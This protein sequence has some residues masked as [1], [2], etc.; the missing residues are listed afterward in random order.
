MQGDKRSGR[1]AHRTATAFV[2]GLN[3]IFAH[4]VNSAPHTE[5][6]TAGVY[7]TG[8]GHRLGSSNTGRIALE[9]RTLL[10]DIPHDS[11]PQGFREASA[12]PAES[13]SI[14]L[15]L[16]QFTP[17]AANSLK[18]F[19]EAGIDRV[20][21]T[22]TVHQSIRTAALKV[23]EARFRI[24][25]KRS[26]IGT[27]DD[28]IEF[29]PF[30]GCRAQGGA[31]VYLPNAGVI[32]TGP[33]VS[34]G[35]KLSLSEFNTGAWAEALRQLSRLPARHVIPAYGSWGDDRI[36]D[37]QL[38]FITEIRNRVG[39][40]VA[41]G[42]SQETIADISLSSENLVWMPYTRPGTADFLHVYSELRVPQAPFN[43]RP[44]DRSA[45]PPYALVLIGDGPHDPGRL[46]A[47]LRPAFEAAGVVP[48]F[49]VDVNALTAEN[50][51]RVPLLVIYRDG[52][53]RPD[54]DP[55]THFAW[56]RDD[57]QQA[58]SAF[59]ADGGGFLNLHN[60]M[61]L[62][63]EDG[64]YLDLVGGRY[65]GHG[66]LE[67]FHVDVVD[68][69]HPVTQGVSTFF[70]ADEQH[71]P[72]YDADRCHLVLR[73]RSLDGR[74]TGAAGWVREAGNGRVCYLA[75]GHTREALEH[76]MFQRLLQN[77]LQWLLKRDSSGT[78]N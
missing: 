59:V 28:P 51:A 41:L 17:G 35:P 33:L 56:M 67:R 23:P 66:P 47:G 19:I 46:E 3:L 62:Y 45:N 20:Y 31:A 50:L 1:A 52:L 11:E 77:A 6:I 70:I 68:S 76:P 61:G 24:L 27:A 37:R 18:A 74:V 58:V 43:G 5:T 64:A 38:G 4:S 42:R 14:A 30:D 39:H 9:G 32:F 44:P 2:V 25:D 21:C 49:T 29:I 54:A 72:A 36:I 7:A 65:R 75:N 13:D 78:G 26:N 48:Q 55:A 15:V 8:H 12:A 57:Q 63:P 40:L 10:I 34:N 69:R 73:S 22:R 71:T 16:T 53:Q 60:A